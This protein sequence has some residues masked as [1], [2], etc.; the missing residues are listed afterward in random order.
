MRTSKASSVT[1]IRRQKVARIE[2][3]KEDWSRGWMADAR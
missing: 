2:E 1:E 3:V